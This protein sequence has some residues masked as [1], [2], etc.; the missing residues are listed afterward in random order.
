MSLGSLSLAFTV[1]L[2]SRCVGVCGGDG[3]VVVLFLYVYQGKVVPLTLWI[4]SF[5]GWLLLQLDIC[6]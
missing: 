3:G 4:F 5:V 6:P 2:M 1:S